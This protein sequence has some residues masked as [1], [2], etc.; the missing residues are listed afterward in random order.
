MNLHIIGT[1]PCWN[2][3]FEKIKIEHP[4]FYSKKL[5]ICVNC[6]YQNPY[7]KTIIWLHE[8]P[9]I[10]YNLINEI[11]QNPEKFNHT[12]IY[13]CIDELQKYP[14]VRYIHPSNST[15][16]NKPSFMPKK[17]K[18]I[19]MISSNKN[20]T[21]GHAL[22]HNII[23]NLPS[24]V[25]LYGRGFK[26]IQNKYEGLEE[27]YFSIAIENDNTDTYF[28]EKLLDCFL[29][30]TI[31]IYWGCKKT[32]LIFNNSGIIW[33]EDIK[34][35]CNL[36]EKDYEKRLD[37]VKENYKIALKENIDPFDSLLKILKEN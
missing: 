8:S 6:F 15:W 28:S 7:L 37:A 3:L 12:I 34:N 13:T 21:Q 33:L 24:C 14:F 35:F 11:K 5:L 32:S 22:R 31:P 36:N 9:A 19:S 25:D 16:I 1:D 18:L 27:Y 2:I 10:T 4:E 30:C 26:E 17:S 29:T 23:Q 20:F